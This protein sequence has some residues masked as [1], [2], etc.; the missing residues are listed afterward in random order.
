MKVTK[1][2]NR[3][4]NHV[5]EF[6]TLEARTM[7]SQVSASDIAAPAGPAFCCC[8]ACMM[9]RAA[10]NMSGPAQQRAAASTTKAQS[11]VPAKSIPVLSSLPGAKATI[12]LDFNGEAA[13]HWGSYNVPATNAYN[14]SSDDIK[15]I[16]TRVAEKYSAFN[17]NVTT[18]NPGTFDNGK[19]LHV[20]VGGDG[21]W[22]GQVCGG[23]SYVGSFANSM[24]NVNFVFSDNLG[25]GFPKYVA[26]AISH[27]CGHAFGLEH[28]SAYSTNSSG[29]AVAKLSEYSDNSGNVKLA[30]TMGNSYS[31]NRGLWWTGYDSDGSTQSDMSTIAS[32][33]NGFGYRKDDFGSSLATAKKLTLSS[34]RATA[35]GVISSVTD[36]DD[37][38]FTVGKGNVTLKVRGTAFGGDLDATLAIYRT[39]GKLIARANTSGLGENLTVQNLA[40]GK[41]VAVVSSHGGY[42]DVGQYT[43][44]A[45]G[46][47]PA[48]AAASAPMGGTT[49]PSTSMFSSKPIQSLAN[50]LLV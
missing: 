36:K 38:V 11:S 5:V 24:P 37:F 49:R 48:P 44:Y 12:Y 35:H 39:N 43:V 30:P 16:W 6:S 3:S 13:Q 47:Q 7:Y 34:G 10:I 31:A 33:T 20:I 4:S 14:G 15:E 2:K 45:Y 23:V 8:F 40:A 21:G 46:D 17:L 32:S 25:A 1:Q 27:E 26:E 18:V 28:Q 22:S 41:Y 19:A 29:Q 50:E 9:A 42:G